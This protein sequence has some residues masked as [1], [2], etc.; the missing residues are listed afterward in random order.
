[1]L[2]K[3]IYKESEEE[4][5]KLEQQ[6]DLLSQFD[7]NNLN[8]ILINNA[9][10]SGRNLTDF[11]AEH[12][13]GAELIRFDSNNPP[14]YEPPGYNRP[15]DFVVS[16]QGVTFFLQMKKLSE[17]ERDNRR[18][19]LIEQV[20]RSLQTI[21]VGKFM[22]IALSEE[23]EESELESFI[24]FINDS[25][26][27]I[28]DNLNVTYPS[29]NVQKAII[30]FF[31]P[32]NIELQHLTVG[33]TTDMEW[34]DL[35]NQAEDQVRNSLTKAIGAFEWDNDEHNINLIVM[36]AD[37]YDD[38][39]ISQAVFGNEI[40]TYLTDGS[41]RPHRDSDGFFYDSNYS[42]KICGII[43]LRRI[44]KTLISCYNKTLFI[45]E[46]YSHMIKTVKKVIGIDKVFT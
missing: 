39:D 42:S 35:T 34:L 22:N 18:N 21:P 20:K 15:P 7:L 37:S 46:Q 29:G 44:D 16:K 2:G 24:S 26:Y 32:N 31:P 13:F 1:M 8:E 19:K 5:Q 36:E 28:P 9:R 45:N 23:F 25:I 4:I 3:T 27:S 6:M 12:N 17:S 38:I 11:V 41:Y 33:S 14:L 43:A 10:G 40:Y 30:K